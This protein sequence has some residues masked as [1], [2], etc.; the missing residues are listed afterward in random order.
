[1]WPNYK[2]TIVLLIIVV[3]FAGYD[4]FWLERFEDVRVFNLM[5]EFVFATMAAILFF[6]IDQL[7][8][9]KYY[10]YLNVG[11]VL[12]FISMYIDALDQLHFHGELYTAI[13]EKLTLVIA[14]TLIIFGVKDWISDFVNLNKILERQVITDELT[15]LYN[16]RGMLQQFKAFEAVA[17]KN[18]L[19]LSFVI[20]DLDDFKK[21]NDTMG[22][23]AGDSF[24]SDLGKSLLEL[25]SKNQVIGR[26]GGE[27]FAICL[28]GSDVNKA[29]EFAEKIRL[30]VLGIT[31]PPKMGNEKISV[32]LGVAELKNNESVMDTIK[33]ADNSLYLAKS[34]GKN[35]VVAIRK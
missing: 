34:N 27:E 20:A 8:G 15:G 33:R 22:H 18:S 26:W 4:F 24:L 7:K 19:S 35:Q 17:Q 9:K 29:C 32:S 13:G 23:L 6:T 1:M 5:A 3:V 25:M 31:M 14:F 10:S 21:Y 28:L 16:R 30:R 11:F 2:K 12:A